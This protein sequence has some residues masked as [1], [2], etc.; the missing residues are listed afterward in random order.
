MGKPTKPVQVPGAARAATTNTAATDGA[1]TADAI[2][3]ASKKLDEAGPLTAEDYAAMHSTEV[4]ATKL[5]KAVLCKD[6]W[7]VPDLPAQ[8]AI[9]V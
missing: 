8:A 3:K 2:V 6:G 1:I 4:D 9:K 5:K 7:V